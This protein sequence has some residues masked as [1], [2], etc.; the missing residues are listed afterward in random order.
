MKRAGGFGR[1]GFLSLGLSSLAMALTDR[2]EG[3]HEARADQGSLGRAKSCIVLWMSGGPSHIDTFDPKPGASTGGPAKAIKTAASGIQISEHLPMLAAR[4]G[5]IAFLRGM[6]SKEGNHQRAQEFGRT[7]HSPNPTVHA[8]SIGSWVAKYETRQGLELPSFVSLGG[9]S[10]GG[11]FLG[12]EYDPLAI[13]APG[14][15]PDDMAPFQPLST[16]RDARRRA[17]LADLESDFA[18]RTGDS[19]IRTRDAIAQRATTMMRSSQASAFSIDGEPD[20]VK[21]AYGD[22]AFGRGCLTARR[23]VESGVPFV[24]VT[25]DGWDTH[26]DNFNRTAKLMGMLDPASVDA[27]R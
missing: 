1:R 25:L 24:E 18:K 8:P 21:N 20:A 7:G 26:K 4:A 13:S 6:T 3:A 9:T 16:D 14:N 17:A 19:Q 23:L 2:L 27:S 5:H 15:V 11:G 10:Y 22:S 12:K